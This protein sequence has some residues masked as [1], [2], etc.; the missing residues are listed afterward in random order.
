[1]SMGSSSNINALRQSVRDR[2]RRL[3]IISQKRAAH[4]LAEAITALPVF[5]R[6]RRIALYFAVDGELSCLPLIKQC[7]HYGKICYMPVL[8]T[9]QSSPPMLFA[10]Y[11]VGTRLQK[12]PLQYI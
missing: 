5:H 10:P 8:Q 12:K 4:K 11:L 7:W 6:S 9:K 1:M 3:G 2:R